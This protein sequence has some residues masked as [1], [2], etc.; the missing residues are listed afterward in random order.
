MKTTRYLCTHCGRRFEA[1]EKEILECPGCF[2]STSVKKEEDAVLEK[3]AGVKD[4]KPAAKKFPAAALLRGMIL[5][6]AIAAAGTFFFT[7]GIPLL[8]KIKIT[9]PRF[10]DSPKKEE[11]KKGQNPAAAPASSLPA[12][13]EMNVLS[14]RVQL[15]P[16]RA[17]LPEEEQILKNKASFRTGI[18][19]K[20]PSQSWTLENFEQMIKEQER[21]YKVPLPGSYKRKLEKQ[22]KTVYLAAGEA[23]KSGDLLQ[24]RNL[25]VESLA[26]PIYSHDIQKHKGVA[27]TM[28]RPFIADTLSKI[29]A[30]NGTLVERTIREKEQAVTQGYT[31]LLELLEK[32]DW[33][34]ALSEAAKIEQT[35]GQ[36]SRPE[37][38]AGSVPPYPQAIQQIDSDIQATLYGIQ[39]A[40]PPAIADLGPL[41]KDIQAKKRIVESFQAE[42]IQASQMAYDEALT[43]IE[44]R[45]WKEAEAKLRQ[46]QTPLPLVQDARQKIQILKKL[47]E[48][49]LALHPEQG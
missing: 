2:W 39:K 26:L 33:Q 22:F 12:P 38:M 42:N 40:P 28:L 9:P 5:C 37:E 49:E 31:R 20:L 29:G 6:A 18:S 45:K 17:L 34:A 21:F 27:L 4:E 32:K 35:L 14:R 48:S 44:Q 23:F 13:E 7:A 15:T 3:P 43:L 41:Q 11:K 36:F 30:I 16:D 46:I 8:Q 47:S 25:W 10:S 1:E 19:E 24:A